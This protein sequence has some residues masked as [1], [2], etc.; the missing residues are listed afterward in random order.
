MRLRN[1][2]ILSELPHLVPAEAYLAPGA[3]RPGI[4]AEERP[5]VNSAV[6]LDRHAVHKQLHIWKRGHESLRH[7]GDSAAPGGQSSIHAK[8]AVQREK[9]CHMG[10]VLAA[11][12]ARVTF[13][14]IS[15]LRSLNL[16]PHLSGSPPE[17]ALPQLSAAGATR[18][19]P[20]SRPQQRNLAS[21]AR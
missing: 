19:G 14:K 18:P 8:R 6:A 4:G 10:R 16:H 13:R 11:P 7:L 21:L 5:V 20:P 3:S 17:F 15:Q 12:C 1:Q 9:R 2:S